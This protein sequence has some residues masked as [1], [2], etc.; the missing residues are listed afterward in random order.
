M[1]CRAAPCWSVLYCGALCSVV[2]CRAA[3]CSDV[4]CHGVAGC[5][6][7]CRAARCRVVVCCVVASLVVVRCTAVRCGASCRVASCCAAYCCAVV[8]DGPFSLP[9]RRRAGLALDRLA[10]FVVR[11]VGRGYVARWWLGGVVRCGVG[12]W[13]R[14]RESWCAVRFAGSGG[15]PQGCPPWGRVPWSCVLWGSLPQV[16]GVVAVSSSSSGACAV[17]RVVALAAAAVVAW[18]RGR[19]GGLRGGVLGASFSGCSPFFPCGCALLP[20]CGVQ[21]SVGVSPVRF[22][23]RQVRGSAAC[24]GGRA[25]S[26]AGGETVLVLV[27]GRALPVCAPWCPS[28]RPLPLCHGPWSVPFLAL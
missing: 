18:R 28:L 6:V 7:L 20:L 13:I 16:L 3:S 14:L 4:P 8:C 25:P 24:L 12:R 15:C 5:A 1:L 17:A 9:F 22:V 11:D 19:G 21:W 2:P 27:L 26:A 10:R 23:R